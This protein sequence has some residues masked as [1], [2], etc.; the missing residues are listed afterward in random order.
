M[1]V[2]NP[3][4]LPRLLPSPH[5]V[6]FSKL[7]VGSSIFDDRPAW[8]FY[9]WLMWVNYRH[10]CACVLMPNTIL[11]GLGACNERQA[12]LDI[13]Q[14][15]YSRGRCTVILVRTQFLIFWY[16]GQVTYGKDNK[17]KLNVKKVNKLFQ[18]LNEKCSVFKS[19]KLTILVNFFPLKVD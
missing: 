4:T 1:L 3:A 17:R 8:Y 15:M 5:F 9:S 19:S 14:R 16:I 6:A 10:A 12:I 2:E 7:V 11:S 18:Y 13:R